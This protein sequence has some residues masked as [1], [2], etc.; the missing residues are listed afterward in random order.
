LTGTRVFTVRLQQLMDGQSIGSTEDRIEASSAYEAERIAI[1]AWTKAGP[2][3][4]YAPLVT[5]EEFG[6]TSTEFD[7]IERETA[8]QR[9][10]S[11]SAALSDD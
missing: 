6:A 7:K 1:E 3:L 2:W 11:D 10:A 9:H 4:T 5:V 8:L